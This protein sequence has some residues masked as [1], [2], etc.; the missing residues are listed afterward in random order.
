MNQH[1]ELVEAAKSFLGK[2]YVWGGECDSEG[3]YDCSG[4]IY[5]SLTK[6]GYS[7]PRLNSQGY[8][9]KY[10]SYPHKTPAEGC[11]L[12]FGKD[13]KHITHIAIAVDAFYMIESIGSSK[14][15]KKNPGKGVC[16]SL[17]KRRSDLVASIDIFYNIEKYYPVYNGTS[18]KID[19]VFGAIGAPYG[20]VS[21]RSYVAALNGVSNYKGTASQNLKLIKLAKSG[22]LRR[23]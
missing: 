15:N 20:N 8:F 23:L 11:L 18:L 7:I 17:I 12:F 10:Q 5:A 3:G 1:K 14:N 16:I 4:L 6:I 22:K 9:N 21:K 13:S 19:V 2:K